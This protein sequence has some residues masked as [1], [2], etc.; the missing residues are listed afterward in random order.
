MGKNDMNRRLQF[1][2]AFGRVLALL[3]PSRCKYISDVVPTRENG[4]AVIDVTFEINLPSRYRKRGISPTGVGRAE[5]ARFYFPDDFPLN[6]PTPT[7]R[8]DFSRQ[9]PHVQPYLKN[10][11]PV[12]CVYEGDLNELLHRRGIRA[13]FDHTHVWLNRAAANSLID[14]EQGWEPMR[15]DAFSKHG[16][17]IDTDNLRSQIDHDSYN[18][19]LAF[20]RLQYLKFSNDLEASVWGKMGDREL[21]IGE[22]TALESLDEEP[23]HKNSDIYQGKS[24]ALVVWS[25]KLPSGKL[26]VA[27]EYLPEEV[28]CVNDLMQ[29]AELY[30]CEKL[31][32]GVNLLRQWL[33]TYSWR[34]LIPLAIILAARRPCNLIGSNSPIELCPYIVKIST[35]RP[36]S[37]NTAAYPA[38]IHYLISRQLLNRVSGGSSATPRH[39][40]TLLGAGSLGSKLALHLARAGHAPSVV[41]DHDRLHSHNM[42]RHALTPV[43]HVV[44]RPKS[45]SLCGVLQ[46]LD[47]RATPVVENIVKILSDNIGTS[48]IWARNT[49]F[50]V[51]ATASHAVSDA[52]AATTIPSHPQVIVT[53][54][55]AN[56]RIG[57]MA[58]EGL[59]H[60]PSAADLISEFHALIG[61]RP[62][63]AAI[64]FPYDNY[65]VVEIGQGCGSAT[66][67]MTDSRLAL[68]AAGMSEHLLNLMNKEVHEAK[69]KILIG[70]LTEDSAGLLWSVHS[71]PPLEII[72]TRAT[73]LSRGSWQAR[74][75]DRVKN[76]MQ[77]EIKRW[78]RLETGGVL[79]GETNES[80]RTFHVI[81]L[82]SPPKG[83][84]RTA[85]EFVLEP[86]NIFPR[87]KGYTERCGNTLSF[88]GTWHSHLSSSEPSRQDYATARS[89]A[90]DKLTPLLFLVKTPDDLHAFHTDV[91]GVQ[92]A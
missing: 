11:R 42:A 35:H 89:L 70:E 52:I 90:S 31:M 49:V 30:G 14:L 60:N 16:L 5:T 39:V 61:E 84:V 41:V 58:V 19:C 82:I 44:G 91:T 68:F 37:M 4:E 65:D 48:R 50:T 45:E 56:G 22:K 63:L 13:V 77:S 78:P 1:N 2:E 25:G 85:T 34:G 20:F 38:A 81:D 18:K 36:F 12:P 33:A 27:K 75:S 54:L 80:S 46:E 55:L 23:V 9:L 86:E 29:L 7:L 72:D 62:D 17:Y 32:T 10:G 26:F 76:K 88:I 3:S 8:K 59:G 73:D 64:I 51:D 83:S 74:I 40:W 87:I 6:V 43:D 67:R 79:L 24:L 69:G 21:S 57:M 15:R 47:Q 53:M 66:M 28:R 71:I 92:S